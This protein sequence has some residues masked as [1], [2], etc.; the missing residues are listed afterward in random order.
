MGRKPKNKIQRID[1]AEQVIIENSEETKEIVKNSEETT[2]N[3]TSEDI[4]AVTDTQTTESTKNSIEEEFVEKAQIPNSEE[5]DYNNKISNIIS[6]L[7]QDYDYKFL[8]KV[9]LMKIAKHRIHSQVR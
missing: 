1:N 9:S 2:Q 6:E 5:L 4:P 8:S 7:K 3:E